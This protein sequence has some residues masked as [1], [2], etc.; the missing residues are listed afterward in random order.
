MTSLPLHLQDL[1]R[2]KCKALLQGNSGNPI[3]I[4]D[5]DQDVVGCS[6]PDDVPR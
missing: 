6:G 2:A 1:L 5:D 3:L 4:E